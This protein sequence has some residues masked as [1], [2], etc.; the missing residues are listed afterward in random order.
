VRHIAASVHDGCGE[1]EE[2]WRRAL[3]SPSKQRGENK[4]KLFL[5][6]GPAHEGTV[7]VF[8]E[9]HTDHVA[10]TVSYIKTQK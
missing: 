3:F 10:A 4:S 2:D 7:V 9:K 8:G 1:I 5:G 6:T